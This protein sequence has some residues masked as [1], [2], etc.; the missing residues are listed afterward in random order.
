MVIIGLGGAGRA[1]AQEFNKWPQ[2]KVVTPKIPRQ[3][4][5]EEYEKK[6][7]NLKRSLKGIKDEV[8]F[9][10]CG[11]SKEAACSLRIMEQIKH[12]KIKVLYIYPEMDF[13]TTEAKKRHRV[14]F[15]V[16]QEYTRSGLLDSMYIISNETVE[17]ISGGGSI[18]DHFLKINET[19][20]SMVHYYNIY[21]NT[22]PVLGAIQEPKIISRIR[23]FGIYDVKK[24]E[25]KFLFSLDNPTEACY[26]YNITR[27]DLE[28]NNRILKDIKEKAKFIASNN[29][30]SSF[31]IYETEYD[32]NFCHIITYTHFVQEEK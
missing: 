31:A 29:I 14:V 26:I 28:S 18:I 6:T 4:T 2:Y 16:L 24:D 21:R 7:P 30:N 32:Q 1:I 27:N 5:V 19:I 13:L 8:W 12:C 20:A 23:T 10:I 11:T 15:R 9:I 25:E 22:D 17:S 3:E